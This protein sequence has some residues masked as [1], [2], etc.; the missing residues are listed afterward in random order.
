VA[1]KLEDKNVLGGRLLPCGTDPMTGYFRDGSCST[2]KEDRGSHTVCAQ[3]TREFLEASSRQGNDLSTPQPA[4]GFPG[5]VPGD[6][7]CLC[8]SRWKE[9]LAL[10]VAPPVILSATHARALEVLSL[11]D[12]VAHAI[13]TN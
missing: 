5:L 2:C 12:L 7:W 8:A 13:D 6:R 3:M 1:Q 9:A 4:Y 11:D 10:G